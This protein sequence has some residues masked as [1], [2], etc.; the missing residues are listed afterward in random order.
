[1]DKQL[2]A[3]VVFLAIVILA[4]TNRIIF[5]MAAKNFSRRKAQSIIVIAGLMIGTSIISA[6]LVVQDTM[7]YGSEVSVYQSLGEIDEQ[8][9][10][11]N[12]YGTVVYFNESIYDEI[13]DL[14]NT[15][16]EIEAVAPAISEW[17]S[18]FDL[19]TLLGEP[20]AAILGLDSQVLR[21]TVFGD[22]D[23]HGFYPDSLGESEVAINSRLADEMDTSVGIP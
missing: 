3:V 13:K 6:S 15:V 2:I 18:V 20:R 4:L 23:D 10:G 22:L 14:E 17:G 1:M 11:L 5:K 12:Q 8:I 7:A 16:P 21:T 9:W 19:D